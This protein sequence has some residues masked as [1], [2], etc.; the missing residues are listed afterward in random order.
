[1]AKATVPKNTVSLQCPCGAELLIEA[2]LLGRDF[3]CPECE[4]Y[5]RASLQ[6][7]L[8]DRSLAPNLTVQCTCGHFVIEEP[9]RAGKKA[10]CPVCKKNLIMPQPVVKFDSPGFVRVPK[11]ALERQLKRVKSSKKR[12]TKEMTRLESAAHSGRISLRPGEHICPN[13]ECGALLRAGA[14]VCSECGTNRLTGKRYDAE[15]PEEDPVG[16]WKEV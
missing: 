14:N 7:V 16:K 15:G 8:A 11:K 12:S 13:M 9:D 4:R 5:I 3:R 10:R 2:N 1:M 6:F